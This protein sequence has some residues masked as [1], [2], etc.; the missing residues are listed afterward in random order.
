MQFQCEIISLGFDKNDDPIAVAV[1]GYIGFVD[2]GLMFNVHNGASVSVAVPHPLGGMVSAGEGGLI[3]WTR[4]DEG[5]QS[6]GQC[7]ES[8]WLETMAINTDAMIMA[9]GAARQVS[10]FDLKTNQMINQFDHK[11]SVSSLCFDSKGRKLFASTYQGVA[12]WFS[13]LSHQSQKLMKW[14]G[15]HTM[16]AISPNDRFLMTAMQDNALH[17]WRLSDAKD[18]RMGGYPAKIRDLRFF[19][20]GTML[21]T[22][23]ASGVVVWPFFKSTGPMGEEAHEIHP[24]SGHHVVKLAGAQS[25]PFVAAALD[26]GRVWLADLSSQGFEWVRKS[27]GPS[28][29]AMAF[30]GKGDRLLIGDESGLVY[31]HEA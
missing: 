2:Q 30:N 13:R 23:G 11:H 3:M 28:V 24:Q 26:D 7:G 10:V 27:G 20:K 17:G 9:V 22:S 15:S 31:S 19:A 29:T 6:I 12:V 21:A 1:D 25:H 5:T 4:S 16:V 8:C 14:E 18:M